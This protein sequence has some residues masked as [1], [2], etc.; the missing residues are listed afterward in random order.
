MTKPRTVEK[1]VRQARSQGR[2]LTVAY[3]QWF[4]GASRR[5]VRRAID[6]VVGI[7]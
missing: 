7:N 2:P 1:R 3:L 5:R 6:V 4:T